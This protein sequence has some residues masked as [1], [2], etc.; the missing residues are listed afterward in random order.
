[1]N[2]TRKPGTALLMDLADHIAEQAKVTLKAS[3]A[4]AKMFSEIAATHL[5]NHWGGQLI[6]T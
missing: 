2:E 1:M 6:Y 4:D 5:A 3:D